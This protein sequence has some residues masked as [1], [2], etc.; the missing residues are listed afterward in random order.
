MVA[1]RGAFSL[2]SV[3]QNLQPRGGRSPYWQCR[4][5]PLASPGIRCDA[6]GRLANIAQ[7]PIF[8][9][10]H[11][12]LK[13]MVYDSPMSNSTSTRDEENDEEEVDLNL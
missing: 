11:S 2:L 9:G 1:R 8:T 12:F 13:M 5:H 6:G 7:D 4:H 10:V 3:S